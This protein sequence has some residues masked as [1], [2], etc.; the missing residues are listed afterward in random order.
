[1]ARLNITV[2]IKDS[3]G[4]PTGYTAFIHLSGS[5][6]GWLYPSGGNTLGIK[7]GETQSASGIPAG[8]VISISARVYDGES[9][10]S[11]ETG[12]KVYNTTTSF[13]HPDETRD[14]TLTIKPW[15]MPSDGIVE[16]IHEEI[17]I[18]GRNPLQLSPPPTPTI[19]PPGSPLSFLWYVGNYKQTGTVDVKATVQITLKDW[20]KT[21]T[22]WS[23]KLETPVYNTSY[24]DNIDVGPFE[25]NLPQDLTGHL[26]VRFN[27]SGI[28]IGT[29]L[30]LSL[31][32]FNATIGDDPRPPSPPPRTDTGSAC[33]FN[34]SL[35]GITN[36]SFVKPGEE[37][38]AYTVVKTLISWGHGDRDRTTSF[39]ATLEAK[40]ING[41]S[42]WYDFI[43][44]PY[45][46]IF[47]D[48]FRAFNIS[49]LLPQ[50]EPGTLII[51][52]GGDTISRWY[53]ITDDDRYSFILPVLTPRNNIVSFSPNKTLVEPGDAISFDIQTQNIG[54][55]PGF[56]GSEILVLDEN[57][58]LIVSTPIS[59]DNQ[60]KNRFD[61]FNGS[62]EYLIPSTY[63]GR[64]IKFGLKA[65]SKEAKPSFE[66]G[67]MA[68][69]PFDSEALARD[70]SGN[71]CDG[72]VFGGDLLSSVEGKFKGGVKF[73]GNR[74]TS[75]T[76]DWQNGFI[77]L[78]KRFQYPN[79]L[80]IACW[81]N[82]LGHLLDNQ[83]NPF[84]HN[85]QSLISCWGIINHT[86]E[87]E[88]R[89]GYGLRV[90][91]T[92]LVPQVSYHHTSDPSVPINRITARKDG[93][94]M[95]LTYDSWHH[96]C[97]TF[98]KGGEAR[99]YIDGILRGAISSPNSIVY[100][101]HTGRLVCHRLETCLG[102]HGQWHTDF[103]G[104]LDEVRFWNRQLSN[105][106]V[107]EIY[108]YIP[109][110]F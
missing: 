45:Q 4:E 8:E 3:F 40:D 32:G 1:M 18:D 23:E 100:S 71:R 84:V 72:I 29:W 27:F 11:T 60:S 89:Y 30:P 85:S 78:G 82:V 70:M 92:S 56:L 39:W 33:H 54:N 58:N 90:T 21:T 98:K 57:N 106:E 108:N 53:G 66:N 12:Y 26:Y 41:N 83:G 63:T 75:Y 6:S 102:G 99:I 79:E 110:E 107:A 47:S 16:M 49:T 104:I 43:Q 25:I 42:Y 65:Y 103:N 62:F 95:S 105:T 76:Y 17:R 2:H 10:F 36:S 14:I 7:D 96:M 44:S 68:Y 13:S 51:T 67:L 69:Y 97:F 34:Y 101:P 86:Y 109:P 5:V 93:R 88:E 19:I 22:L 28:N 73:P 55:I 20:D 64:S 48:G 31:R 46:T 81:F 35:G 52:F 91:G 77:N 61:T 87:T 74:L 38:T 50:L 94:N 15:S 59:S 24:L 37:F 9:S 80:S